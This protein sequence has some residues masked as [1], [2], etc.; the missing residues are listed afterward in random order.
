M[1]ARGRRVVI[2]LVP[3]DSSSEDGLRFQLYKAWFAE[4]A[5]ISP[6]DVKQLVPQPHQ[7]HAEGDPDWHFFRGFFKSR[8]EIDRLVSALPPERGQ[9]PEG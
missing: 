2:N 5:G 4:R 7:D 6:A 8:E 9:L 1:R 3:G